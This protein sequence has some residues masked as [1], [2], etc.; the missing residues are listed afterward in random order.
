MMTA[1]G[2]TSHVSRRL[3][4]FVVTGKPTALTGGYL[5]F[6]WRVPGRPAPIV[7][8]AAPPFVASKPE[9]PLSADRV[10]FEAAALALFLETG[11]LHDLVRGI[12]SAP[13]LLDFDRDRH[14]LILQD[15]GEGPALDEI[16]PDRL[17]SQWAEKLGIFI[18]RLH[19]RT[20]ENGDVAR[21]FDNRPVQATRDAL[22]YQEAHRLLL[23]AG[24]PRAAALSDR[25]RSLGRQLLQS[26]RCLTM[27]DL[28]PRSLLPRGERLYLID[29]EFA[30][31][32]NPAQDLGHLAAHLWMLAHRSGDRSARAAWTEARRLFLAEYSWNAAAVSGLL[33]ETV[34]EDAAVHFGCELLAR[35]VGAFQRG[36]L[37]EGLSAESGPVKEAIA[38]AAHHLEAPRDTEI[39]RCLTRA[40]LA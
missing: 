37:Y 21:E 14:L 13:R 23:A 38:T 9:I 5:N 33:D 2:L 20:F 22:Q 24:V 12:I 35:T 25:A 40:A 10:G 11:H 18:G 8:K 7:V 32:G 3:D 31:F 17:P 28:W 30:H 19:A 34:A 15:L 29:W 27:G 6:V 4:C 1:E 26:G 16:A 39:F 36:Y